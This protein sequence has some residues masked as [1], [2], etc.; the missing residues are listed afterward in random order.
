MMWLTFPPQLVRGRVQSLSCWD[1]RAVLEGHSSSCH[2]CLCFGTAWAAG[3]ASAVLAR[4]RAWELEGD[5]KLSH[6]FQGEG[7]QVGW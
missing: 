6:P 4:S 1:Q 3:A 7:E 5:C 2:M